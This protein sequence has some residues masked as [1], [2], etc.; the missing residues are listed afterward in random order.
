MVLRRHDGEELPVDLIRYQLLGDLDAD[1]FLEDGDV[2]YVTARRDS[3]SVYGRVARSGFIEFRRGDAVDDLIALAGGFDSGADA[4]TVELRRFVS[5]STEATTRRTLDITAGEGQLL[6]EPGDGVYVRSQSNWRRERLVELVGEVRYPGVY[7][8]EKDKETLR[9]LIDRAGGFTKD[10]DPAGTRVLRPNVFDVPE[11]DPEFLRLQSIPISEMTNDEYEYL[12][13]RSRQREG[14][15]SSILSLHLGDPEFG[16]D[17]VLRAGDRVEVPQQNLAVDVQGA[18]KNPGF[19]PYDP[20][21]SAKDYIA[22]A[23]GV[24]DRARTGK[25]RVIRDRTGERVK[26]DD[27]TRV[28]PGDMVWVPEKPERDWWRIA[29]EAAVFLASIGTLIVVVDSVTRQ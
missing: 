16:E 13:L 17:L 22:L 5:A 29:R 19:V 11:D 21:L 2:L 20:E 12:K 28:D 18:V 9:S 15:S 7:A 1:P 26:V 10:A 25:T 8:I 27:K 14:H 4:H 24:S 6:A 23:G 3:V